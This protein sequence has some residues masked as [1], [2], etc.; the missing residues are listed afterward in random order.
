[1]YQLFFEKF[2]DIIA[3]SKEEQDLIKSYLKPKKLRKKQYLLQEGDPCKF[4]AFVEKGALRSYTI[5]ESGKEY[6][7]QFALEGSLI[8]DLYSFLT[9]DPST[10]N[11]DALENSELL[12]TDKSAYEE[13]LKKLPA[14]ETYIR[15]QLTSAFIAMHG[16]L[17]PLSVLHWKIV[18]LTLP[19]FTRI[20]FS[21][22]HSI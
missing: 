19:V 13:L 20:L 22:C 6:I 3:V 2:N 10:Y 4:I 1:M 5:D 12:I 18:I 17:R 21:V 14:Y 15:L 7:L 11:I 8:S 9:G 16:G